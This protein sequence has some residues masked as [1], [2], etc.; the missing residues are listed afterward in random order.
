MPPEQAQAQHDLIGPSADVYSIGV[1]LYE[2]LTGKTPFRDD[3]VLETLRQIREDRP[4]PP[5]DLNPAVPPELQ[6]IC[7]RCLEKAPADRYASAEQLAY[8]LEHYRRGLTAI[9]PPEHTSHSTGRRPAKKLLAAASALLALGLLTVVGWKTFSIPATP[10]A[11]PSGDDTSA[12]NSGIED[13]NFDFS[14][15]NTSSKPGK[16]NQDEL[17]SPSKDP[18]TPKV[19]GHTHTLIAGTP[20]GVGKITFRLELDKQW[21]WSDGH[22]AR[23]STETGQIHYPTF[24]FDDDAATG[25]TLNVWFLY[26]GDEPPAITLSAGDV[27]LAEKVRLPIQVSGAERLPLFAEWWKQYAHDR[28]PPISEELALFANVAKPLLKRAAR[29]QPAKIAQQTWNDIPSL[30]EFIAAN[31]KLYPW[32]A[33]P[34]STRA[35]AIVPNMQQFS[36]KLDQL[37]G[38]LNLP[39]PGVL[40]FS[41]AQSG[42]NQGLRRDGPL[43]WFLGPRQSQDT[44]TV[45]LLPADNY[46]RMIRRLHPQKNTPF[47]LATVNG[48]QYEVTPIRDHAA[49]TLPNQTPWMLT[50]SQSIP[51]R[52][53]GFD[54]LSEFLSRQDIGFAMTTQAAQEGITV[55][56][57]FTKGDYVLPPTLSRM[58]VRFFEFADLTAEATGVRIVSE[59]GVHVAAAGAIDP[60]SNVSRFSATMTLDRDDLVGKLPASQTGAVLAFSTCDEWNRE[61]ESLLDV[62]RYPTARPVDRKALSVVNLESFRGLSLALQYEPELPSDD[63]SAPLHVQFHVDDAQTAFEAARNWI[64]TWL[65]K[66]TPANDSLWIVEDDRVLERDVLTIRFRVSGT[67]VLGGAHQGPDLAGSLSLAVLDP[68]TLVLQGGGPPRLATMIE[69]IEN[70]QRLADSSTFAATLEMMHPEAQQLALIDINSALRLYQHVVNQINFKQIDLL[71][72]PILKD[73]LVHFDGAPPLGV[74]IK[75]DSQTVETTVSAPNRLLQSLKP[76]GQIAFGLL[77]KN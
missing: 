12:R 45:Y 71:E 67:F 63:V 51:H 17:D 16:G 14:R 3:S 21:N 57:P 22:T 59:Q 34:A 19:L 24:H 43:M 65:K 4:A 9:A 61:L 25:P 73:V 32:S 35:V 20:C 10:P 5:S 47:D 36:D 64:K 77:F 50:C 28:I 52:M 38:L 66:V 31:P 62:I 69:R 70:S 42:I 53:H 2:L 40:E 8:E 29:S 55:R 15:W 6:S 44:P 76:L 13:P 39:A 7:L 68:Q 23:I 18:T 74:N 46:S 41:M 56:V 72:T 27:V 37:A 49:F 11:P 75:L 54:P 33:A 60:A 48:K 30:D 58:A 26:V 1:L